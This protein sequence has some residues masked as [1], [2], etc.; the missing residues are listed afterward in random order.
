M[1]TGHLDIFFCNVPVNSLALKKVKILYS[2]CLE[3][4]LLVHGLPIH[5]L[6][7]DC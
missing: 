1:I 5:F 6:N 7:D 4:L 3:Y 2:T